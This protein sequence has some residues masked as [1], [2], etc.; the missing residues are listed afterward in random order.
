MATLV[1]WEPFRELAQHGA[2]RRIR[3]G[4]KHGIEMGMLFNHVVK[5]KHPRWIVNRSV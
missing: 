2:P 4:M 3:E 1:R 5:H